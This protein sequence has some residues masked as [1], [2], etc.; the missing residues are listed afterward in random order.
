MHKKIKSVAGSIGLITLLT[1]SGAQAGTYSLSGFAALDFNTA[2]FANYSGDAAFVFGSG[3]PFTDATVTANGYHLANDT[4]M[5]SLAVDEDGGQVVANAKTNDLSGL[6]SVRVSDYGFGEAFSEYN[7][8]YSVVGNG[9]I[10][11]TVPYQLTVDAATS[12]DADASSNAYAMVGLE[13]SN[14]TDLT[15]YILDWHLGDGNGALDDVGVLS[16]LLNVSDG[17]SGSLRFFAQAGADLFAPV[18]GVLPEPVPLPSAMVLMLTGLSGLF[19]RARRR[20]VA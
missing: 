6:A 9:Q 3:Q 7:L 16:L 15:T 1:V 4:A 5:S 12:S 20:Q 14:L 11:V 10:E 18:P 19:F 2:T 8:D 17:D 13:S